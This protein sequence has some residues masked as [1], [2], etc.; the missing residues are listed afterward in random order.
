MKKVKNILFKLKM[1]GEGIVNYDS[2]DQKNQF[3]GTN[4][5][6][7]MDATNV[8]KNVSYAK[9]NFYGDD[10]NLSYKIKIS[11]NCLRHGIFEGDVKIQSPNIIHHE[12]VLHSFIASP[13]SILRGYI[14]NS[15]NEGYKRSGAL[16][17]DDAEQTCDAKSNIETF[18]RSG[19]KETDAETT[20]NSFFKKETIGKI[21]YESKGFIDLM[22][23]Q[24][25]SCDKVFDRFSFNPDL[26]P[27]YKKFL[28][29]K[30]PSFNSELGYYQIKDSIIEIPEYGFK[31][32]NENLNIIIRGLFERL[33]K[34]NIL[35][36][37]AY[38]STSELQYKLVYDSLEDTMNDENNWVTIKSLEDINSFNVEVEDFY[39]PEDIDMAKSKREAIEAEYIRVRE[40]NK[41]NDKKDREAKKKAAEEAKSKK[42]T[43]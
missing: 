33:L 11:S 36:S 17:I 28:Q 41:A 24:F 22:Q 21:K 7:K 23:L 42:A 9:K 25:V 34:L 5:K 26:F 8:N 30:L 27:V 39:L 32:D 15:R 19:L 3:Y 14:L 29:T 10:D 38:A 6:G 35:R 16:N 31:L 37:G 1:N 12:F 40:T 20:D 2:A 18:S 43:A 4:L 13:A